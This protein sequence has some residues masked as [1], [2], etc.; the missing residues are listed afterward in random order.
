MLEF[1]AVMAPMAARLT[2]EAR[3][4]LREELERAVER[5]G[6]ERVGGEKEPWQQAVETLRAA[7]AGTGEK[8]ERRKRVRQIERVGESARA[9]GAK[10]SEKNEKSEKKE[11]ASAKKEKAPA[12]EKAPVKE[13]A[14]S[15]RAAAKRTTKRTSPSSEKKDAAKPAK[16]GKRSKS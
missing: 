4:L 16:R 1:A 7:L 3:G 9:R 2:A 14:P 10:K 5:V 6:G 15:K 12:K 13:K 8:K 11:K